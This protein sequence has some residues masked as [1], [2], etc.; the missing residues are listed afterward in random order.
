M[1][2]VIDKPRVQLEWDLAVTKS[3]IN[4]YIRDIETLEFCLGKEENKLEELVLQLYIE[5]QEI[6]K[7]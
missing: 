4:N 7:V 6:M 3:K 5:S 1:E 2:G